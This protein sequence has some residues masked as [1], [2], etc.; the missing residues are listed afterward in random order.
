MANWNGAVASREEVREL[1][2]KAALRV[3]ARIFNE[4]GL[5]ATSVREVVEAAGISKPTLYYYFKNKDALFDE[6]IEAQL[7]GLAMLVDATLNAPGTVRERLRV[8]LEAYVGGGLA[9]PDSVRMLLRTSSALDP[10]QPNRSIASFRNELMRL[11]E[12]LEEGVKN[13]ELRDDLDGETAIAMLCGGADI[14]LMSGLAGNAIPNDFSG[15][16]LDLL[17]RGLQR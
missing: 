8:F 3:A 17:Y 10:T 1:K 5:A 7:R 9:N 13:G 16:M 15:P 11:S 2:R 4:K 12:V 14:V 6:C